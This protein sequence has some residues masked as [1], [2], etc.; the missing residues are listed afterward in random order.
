MQEQ[1]FSNGAP[2]DSL[3]WDYFADKK[4]V[5]CGANTIKYTGFLSNKK[6]QNYFFK[7]S[8]NSDTD[9][10]DIVGVIV[11][12]YKDDATGIVHTLSLFRYYS[13]ESG[14][15][16]ALN[17]GGADGITLQ[18]I[19]T[20]NDTFKIRHLNGRYGG[21]SGGGTFHKKLY[22][23]TVACG[24]YDPANQINVNQST[25]ART[26][27]ANPEDGYYDTNY[28]VNFTTPSS[29]AAVNSVY[30]RTFSVYRDVYVNTGP[31]GNGTPSVNI[32]GTAYS[33]VNY[34]ETRNGRRSLANANNEGRNK[35]SDVKKVVQSVL[36]VVAHN[37]LIFARTHCAQDKSDDV[38][39][40]VQ[41]VKPF[42]TA[43]TSWST[44]WGRIGNSNRTGI[45]KAIKHTFRKT[46]GGTI[47]D[48]EATYILQHTIF[49]KHQLSTTNYS[50]LTVDDLFKLYHGGT[51]YFAGDP[52]G[53]CY[54][55]SV[56]NLGYVQGYGYLNCYAPY[57]LNDKYD[58]EKRENYLK[59]VY[60]D[61]Y[62]A[63]N[64]I[65]S[66]NNVTD[67]G[68]VY[69]NTYHKYRGD[70]TIT[71][72][73]NPSTGIVTMTTQQGS[74]STV[75]TSET[76]ANLKDKRLIKILHEA[77]GYGYIAASN[78]LTNFIDNEFV[79]GT[80]STI[81]DL[82]TN[83]IWK[84]NENN[85][86]V[87]DTSDSTTE[88]YKKFGPGRILSNDITGKVYYT[89]GDANQI[90][91]IVEGSTSII[92]Q[93][94]STMGYEMYDTLKMDILNAVKAELYGST[95]DTGESH[96]DPDETD[97]SVQ[98]EATS[99]MRSEMQAMIDQHTSQIKQELG[100]NTFGEFKAAIKEEMG[101]GLTETFGVFDLRDAN[102]NLI[103]TGDGP[104][105]GSGFFTVTGCTPGKMVVVGHSNPMPS[106][107]QPLG[108]A[109][110]CGIRVVSG[111]LMGR[112]THPGAFYRLGT[113]TL[114]INAAV[115]DQY[116][117]YSDPSGNG[118]PESYTDYSM[119]FVIIPNSDTLVFEVIEMDD[120]GD[121]LYIFK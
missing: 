86:Y 60:K 46:N 52:Q 88:I 118:F 55:G 35:W 31:S 97:A 11:G 72:E 3:S 93:T 39:L 121:I 38:P 50:A 59:I 30:N 120:D 110:A 58:I 84:V 105:I 91:K 92:Q 36:S 28:A 41:H 2:T 76:N 101:Y 32:D 113:N 104:I 40:N 107:E 74:N 61:L 1:P 48:A 90:Q 69:L 18:S 78:P 54:G 12:G 85:V 43:A 14:F 15:N 67:P 25:G 6:F 49:P 7:T 37:G 42:H 44:W 95:V 45:L 22:D 57:N 89:R 29:G 5:F 23:G 106:E 70:I 63:V 114:R 56:T 94:Q 17:P 112:G 65:T 117:E 73:Y 80:N 4:L 26:V 99:G 96:E 98:P 82:E 77:T 10:D 115:S 66:V 71:F 81:Y 8:P 64:G 108:G 83:K 24:I 20:A 53:D 116:S 13:G 33:Y 9:D 34:T 87:M 102:G 68:L 51:Q 16:I 111:S 109:T 79:D 19:N 103:N 21:Y 62:H 119:S 75:A 47:S 27:T 100:Y